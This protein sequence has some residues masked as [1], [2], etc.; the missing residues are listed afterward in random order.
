MKTLYFLRILF[1]LSFTGAVFVPA[2]A[3]AA[4][5]ATTTMSAEKM[6]AAKAKADQEI[7]RRIAALSDLAT[8]VAAMQKV[9]DAFKQALTSSVQAQ[10]TAL[11][12]LKTSI[13][14]ETDATTLKTNIKLLADSHHNFTLVLAQSRVDAAA[15]RLMTLAVMFTALG[16]KLQARINAAQAAGADVTKL[17]NSLTDIGLKLS[18]IGTQAQ[19]AVSAMS[20]LTSDAG[21]KVKMAANAAAVKNARNSLQAGQKDVVAIRKDIDLIVAG[22]KTANV[23]STTT[24]VES[25]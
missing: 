23:T 25:H 18:D 5:T 4:N 17:S 2:L 21:D 8:R 1:A 14:A 12:G 19:S 9:T 7:D 11:A 3:S 24:P 6:T 13:D 16:T 15:D 22:L 20:G 10:A